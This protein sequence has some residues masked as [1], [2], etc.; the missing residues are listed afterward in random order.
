ML[1]IETPG[2]RVKPLKWEHETANTAVYYW[3]KVMDYQYHIKVD[4]KDKVVTYGA[5]HDRSQ[6]ASSLEEAKSSCELHWLSK[7]LPFLEKME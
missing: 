6:K 5:N 4:H 2:Y 7:L 1:R 3:A